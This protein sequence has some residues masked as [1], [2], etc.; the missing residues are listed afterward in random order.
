MRYILSSWRD[1]L[2]LYDNIVHF[3]Q[4]PFHCEIE[5]KIVS[6][7]N[8]SI[9][10]GW[11]NS[12]DANPLSGFRALSGFPYLEDMP[13]AEEI[14]YIWQDFIPRGSIS[15]LAAPPKCGK[16]TL[17]ASV[18][19]AGGEGGEVLG[20]PVADGSMETQTHHGPFLEF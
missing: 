17:L 15:V 5:H 6:A 2:R 10:E 20:R 1:R 7:L 12:E 8:Q 4:Q 14:E 19:K 18:I 13:D 3:F 9:Q 16:S 11:F